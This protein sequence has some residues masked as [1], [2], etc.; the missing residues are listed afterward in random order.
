MLVV[1]AVI[2]GPFADR[3]PCPCPS[4][5]SGRGPCRLLLPAAHPLPFRRTEIAVGL[6]SGR[7]RN[8]FVLAGTHL[9]MSR[10]LLP[11]AVVAVAAAIV[12]LG[13]AGSTAAAAVVAAAAAAVAAV[14]AVAAAAA[15]A[16]VATAAVVE[17][18]IAPGQILCPLMILEWCRIPPAI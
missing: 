16:A 8:G 13:C 18:S 14:A 10:N 11:A 3:C 4:H 7:P 9:M 2:P 6:R 12:A 17:L 1:A 5:S 15:A